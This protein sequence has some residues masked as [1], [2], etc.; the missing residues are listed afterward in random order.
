METTQQH[1]T[2]YHLKIDSVYFKDVVTGKKT[3]EIR[4]DDRGGYKVGDMLILE[5]YAN[6]V[7]LDDE[8]EVEV[9]YITDYAQKVG[10][11]VLGIKPI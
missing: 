9:T 3:F 5:E 11:V 4:K 1:P 6:G 2:L 10:Y 7:Y 8:C